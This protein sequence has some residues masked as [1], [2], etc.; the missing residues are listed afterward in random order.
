MFFGSGVAVIRRDKGSGV[1]GNG[2]G[3][4]VTGEEGR[5]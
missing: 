3:K 2:G 5:S 1:R 4:G